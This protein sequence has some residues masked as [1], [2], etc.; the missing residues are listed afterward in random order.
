M[1]YW[2][3]VLGAAAIIVVAI[4]VHGDAFQSSARLGPELFGD[5]N[6]VLYF[7][8]ILGA[9]LLTADCLS[10]ERREG[11]LGLLFLTP[12]TPTG[13]VA[14]KSVV[15]ALR[16]LTLTAAALPVI[17]LAFLFGGAGWK[18]ALLALMLN[19]S[20][21]MLALG[22]GLLASSLATQA[23]W[24]NTAAAA[25]SALFMLGGFAV[26]EIL[27]TTLYTIPFQPSVSI[28]LE[29]LWETYLSMPFVVT[30]ASGRWANIIGGMDAPRLWA[31]MLTTLLFTL[32]TAGVLAVVVR[33]AARRLRL[34]VDPEISRF[35]ETAWASVLAVPFM[36]GEQLRNASRR[37]LDK[38]PIGWLHQRTTGA[39]LTKWLWALGVACGGS[40]MYH[41]RIGGVENLA[42]ALGAGMAFA[43]AGSFHRERDLGVMELILVSPL[44]VGEIIWG[45]I[46]GL[47]LQFL[48]AV[49]AVAAVKSTYALRYFQFDFAILF[50]LA[51]LYLAMAPI[52]LYFSLA[53]SNL[54]AG[55]IQAIVLALGAPLLLAGTAKLAVHL[56]EDWTTGGTTPHPA[57][58]RSVFF[59]CLAANTI[60]TWR[61]LHRNLSERRFVIQ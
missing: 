58:F 43:A 18:E 55:W 15:H 33:S 13:I 54:V 22:A 45:R 47:W 20:A 16:A 50:Y 27:L 25:L 60:W 39:R 51:G 34:E 56:I 2:L 1:N 44:S 7:G 6:A 59:I 10:R 49:T 52:G 53:A 29:G 35:S 42:L 23:R 32:I 36:L 14:A 31:W 26:Y 19:A 8:I 21:L 17:C 12:L 11:T 41:A 48:P 5:L 3:R 46:R 4:A 28:H 24:A 40:Y 38:N 37:Q 30:G 57:I 61:L 9:P